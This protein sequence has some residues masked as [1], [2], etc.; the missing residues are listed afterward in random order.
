[1]KNSTASPLCCSIYPGQFVP[2]LDENDVREELKGSLAEST[3]M[4]PPVN[5]TESTH[6][7]KVEIAIPGVR[8]EELVIYTDKNI[9]SVC[10]AHKTAAIPEQDTFKLH[11]FTYNYFYRRIELPSNVDAEF[12]SAEYKAG[13]LCLHVPK[14]MQLAKN[15]HTRI[16][17]Y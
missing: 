16:V 13:I 14:S 4:H 9:L 6:S 8:R 15:L 11:E 10:V 5:L 12:I 3:A 1:M 7:V 2:L 17:V